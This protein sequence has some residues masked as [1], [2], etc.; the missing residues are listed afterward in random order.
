MLAH[1]DANLDGATGL[2]LDVRDE[3]SVAEANH[4]TM[5]R[6]GFVPY[7]PSWAGSDSPSRIMA[8]DLRDTGVTVN[9]LLSGGATVTGMLPPGPVPEGMTIHPSQLRQPPARH[10]T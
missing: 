2:G 1:M 3:S 5:Q 4:T 7:G 10:S 9:L 6:A 8:A